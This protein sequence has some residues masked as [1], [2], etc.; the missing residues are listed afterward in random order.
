[1]VVV[2]FV[3]G[4]V[5]TVVEVVVS[6]A[7]VVVSASVVDEV[8]SVLVVDSAM[9]A[10]V[11]VVGVVGTMIAF[12]AATTAAGLSF[13]DASD[14]GSR[15]GGRETSF[16]SHCVMSGQPLSVPMKAHVPFL[17]SLP[18]P[19]SANSLAQSF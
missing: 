18:G 9:M 12:A 16:T 11:V 2:T 6:K 10:L 13:S 1:L 7:V 14:K 5:V 3:V 15:Q 19:V 17:A 8:L 4:T